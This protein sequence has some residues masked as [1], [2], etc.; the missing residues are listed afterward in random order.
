MYRVV[1][2]EG[3]SV[4][5]WAGRYWLNGE[6]VNQDLESV[7]HLPFGKSA[8]VDLSDIS[9]M[10]WLKESLESKQY[11]VIAFES[12]TKE[13]FADD[14]VPEKKLFVL[15]DFRAFGKDSRGF[16]FLSEDK[17]RGRA[18]V[19]LYSCTKLFSKNLSICDFFKFRK[20]RF[21]TRIP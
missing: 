14:L 4:K 11:S 6:S 15:K 5:Y 18:S 19:V 16:G 2:V 3:D 21:F 9:Y 12:G 8:G 7:S 20:G 13:N 1:A 10:K 17:I